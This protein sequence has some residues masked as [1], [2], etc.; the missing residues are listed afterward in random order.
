VLL[1]SLTTGRCFTLAPT[2]GDPAGGATQEGGAPAAAQPG[3]AGVRQ[4]K[5]ILG[6]EAV[7][8]VL[9]PGDEAGTVAAENAAGT[10]QDFAATAHVIEQPRQGFDRLVE[11]ARDGQ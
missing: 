9:G 7:W 4:G 3:Q 10:R 5:T 8:K 6:P 11:R 2:E 1:S